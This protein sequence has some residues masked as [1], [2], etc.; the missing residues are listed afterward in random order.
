MPA[1]AD[2]MRTFCDLQ[3]CHPPPAGVRTRVAQ[4]PAYPAQPCRGHARKR[5]EVASPVAKGS[6]RDGA[7]LPVLRNCTT[8]ARARNA[9]A[10]AA[11]SPGARRAPVRRTRCYRVLLKVTPEAPRPEGPIRRNL[12]RTCNL[13]HFRGFGTA[14]A[15]TPRQDNA[16][17]AA[18]GIPPEPK[19]RRVTLHDTPS[20]YKEARPG[21][22][23]RGTRGPGRARRRHVALTTSAMKR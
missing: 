21:R 13:L 11:R 9:G 1:N 4:G 20:G 6:G 10:G 17:T 14:F 19:K 22:I 2:R 18:A 15:Y 7:G 8:M 3:V 16:A 23:P 5:R 12:L